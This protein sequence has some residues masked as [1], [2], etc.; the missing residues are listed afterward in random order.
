[1]TSSTKTKKQ[2]ACLLLPVLLALLLLQ[3][4]DREQAK[5]KRQQPK[6]QDYR[7][8]IIAMGDSLTAGYGLAEEQAYPALLQKKLLENGFRFKVINAG[9]S[10]ETSSGAL[11]RI[12]WI[13]TAK[14]DIVIFETGANDGLRGIPIQLI[15]D[16]IR[17]AVRTLR[18][19]GVTVVLAGMQMVRNLGPE[20]TRA[21]ADLYKR[22]AEQE[23]VI[24]IPF[25]LEG[26]AGEQSLNQEDTIHPTSAGYRKV[27]ETIYPY[28]VQAIKTLQNRRTEEQQNIEP[29][30]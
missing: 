9:I 13:L 5:D 11:S 10:G 17:Q 26:V 4:C 7:G 14:P 20:Y 2:I 19:N 22:I 28:V 30:K 1:M 23:E 21:F 18:Q 24:F 15:E 12:D 27:V 8:I 25:F 29:Q 16:N 6:E 3:G